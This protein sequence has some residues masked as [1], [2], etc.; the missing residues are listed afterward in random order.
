MSAFQWSKKG[1]KEKKAK[2]K[3]KK[4]TELTTILRHRYTQITLMVIITTVGLTVWP[5]SYAIGAEASSLQ[6]RAKSQGLGWLLN[7]LSNGI[8]GLVLPYIFN[9]DQGA[10][11]AKTGFVYTGFCIVA[12]GLAWLIVPEMKDKSV[13][14][15]DEMFEE[16][17]GSVRV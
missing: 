17:R 4:K 3:K 11:G 7:C 6:L 16:R 10:L 14:E 2:E 9:D 12:L 5:A 8:L 13:V 1:G 15:I